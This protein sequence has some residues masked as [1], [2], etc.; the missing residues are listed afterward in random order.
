M[1]TPARGKTAEYILPLRWTDDS[2]LPDLAAYLRRLTDWIAVTVVDGSAPDLFE[3]H[4]RVF[5]PTVRHL[6]PMAATGNDRPGKVGAGRGGNGKV[7][8]VMTGVRAST[9]DLL[10][11][12]DD[13]VRYTLESLAAVVQHL[14]SPRLLS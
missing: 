2:D 5:P 8:G 10:V 1:S 3:Q 14:S 13:D 7:A 11:I 12:A 4:R 9:A 6:R